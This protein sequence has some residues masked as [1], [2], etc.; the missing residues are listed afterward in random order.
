MQGNCLH[1]EQRFSER[2][3]DLSP[4][5]V[6]RVLAAAK[7]LDALAKKRTL[8]NEAWYRTVSHNGKAIAHLVGQGVY[9]STVLTG[10]M[11]PKGKKV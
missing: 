4:D 3:D 2:L 10:K 6:K 7:G 8:P 1:V 5:E 9:L 11:T